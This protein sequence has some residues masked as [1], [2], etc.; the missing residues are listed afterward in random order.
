MRS[1]FSLFSSFVVFS[2]IGTYLFENDSIFSDIRW[3]YAFA[4]FL[5]RFC[6]RGMILT[7]VGFSD[8]VSVWDGV[9]SAPPI[10]H[11]IPGASVV[12]FQGVLEGQIRWLF[13]YSYI[14]VFMFCVSQDEKISLHKWYC[15]CLVTFSPDADVQQKWIYR[16]YSG[17]IDC[18]ESFFCS[19]LV[20]K[21]KKKDFF[22]S[23]KKNNQCMNRM[24]THRICFSFPIRYTSNRDIWETCID[25]RTFWEDVYRPTSLQRRPSRFW[26]CELWTG[27]SI[28]IWSQWKTVHHTRWSQNT[29]CH[30]NWKLVTKISSTHQRHTI[31]QRAG[32]YSSWWRGHSWFILFISILLWLHGKY[33][34][35]H[36]YCELLLV[37]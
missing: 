31:S 13:S 30:K 8:H 37:F 4:G 7:L 17:R 34:S 15:F 28:T 14:W 3:P 26:A 12:R 27:E 19:A 6:I 36:M 35:I 9:W 1:F 29:I 5:I 32:I 2:H 20:S 23:L 21:E 11:G 10:Y 16:C 25:I 33:E 24:S 18:L 22:F